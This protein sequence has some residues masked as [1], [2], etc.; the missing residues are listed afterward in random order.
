M[1]HAQHCTH[2]RKGSIATVALV[3]VGIVALVGIAY[4]VSKPFAAKVNEATA[5]ATQW[6]PENITKDPVGYFTWA[7]AEL[8]DKEGQL[9]ARAYKLAVEKEKARQ[10]AREN[11]AKQDSLKQVLDSAKNA[12]RALPDVAPAAE[13]TKPAK[14]FP[15]TWEGV[16]F[17]TFDDFKLQ[18]LRTENS[19]K[20]ADKLARQYKL[21]AERIEVMLKEVREIQSKTAISLESASANLE[22]LKSQKTIA[23]VGEIGNSVNALLIECNVLVSD[24][25][26]RTL[27]DVVKEKVANEKVGETDNDFAAFMAQ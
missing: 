7:T 26:K 14:Q 16:E 23:D 11:S 27:D 13:G 22:L 24:G 3:L 2:N 5:Q 8:K 10:A 18:I 20:N 15:F 1:H 21:N 17:K 19:R 4:F 6:T 9:K 25:D 12:Y